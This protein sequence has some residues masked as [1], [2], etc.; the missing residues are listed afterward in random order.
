MDRLGLQQR[1]SEYKVHRMVVKN[2]L[3]LHLPGQFVRL[4]KTW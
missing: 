1:L 2:G 4:H 3:D